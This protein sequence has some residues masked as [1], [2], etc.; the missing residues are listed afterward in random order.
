AVVAN[1]AIRR[2]PSTSRGIEDRH[3]RPGVLI[4]VSRTDA[5]LTLDVALVVRQEHV[6]VASEQRFDQRPEYFPVT[7]GEES[8]IEEIEDL[9]KLGARF[10]M[11]AGT[12]PAG[13]GPLDFG[14]RQTKEEEILRTD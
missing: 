4:A 1:R 12:I 11:A 9:A 10:V 2:E 13:F 14:R 5:L 7:V 8:V 6:V 3:V